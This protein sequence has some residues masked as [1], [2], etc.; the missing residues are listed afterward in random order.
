M[1]AL[2]PFLDNHGLGHSQELSAL[3]AANHDMGPALSALKAP[4]VL[5]VNAHA[6]QR[7][8]FARALAAAN[9]QSLEATDA[10]SMFAILRTEPTEAVLV[11]ADLPGAN[12]ETILSALRENPPCPNLQVLLTSSSG[13]AD[14][15]AKLLL[16][17]ADDYLRLP[18]TP[19]QLAARVKSALSHKDAQDR[20]DRLSRQL[21]DMNAELERSLGARTTDAVQARNAL[22]LALARLVEYRSL[23]AHS[24]LTRMQRHCTTLAQEAAGITA[25]ADQIDPDFLQNIECCAPLHDIGNVGL[26]DHILLKAGR[27]DDKEIRI[28]QTHTTVGADTLQHVAHRFGAKLGF[29][30]MAIDITRH[31]HENYDGSGYPDRLAGNN[32]PLAARIL[33]IADS[34]DSLRSRRAQ[35]PSL[36]HPSSLQIMF[37]NSPGKYDPLL[38]AALKRC[39]GQFERIFRDLPDTITID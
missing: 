2:L 25:F 35:R 23:E 37:D 11:A 19:V 21:L 24:H 17:G 12:G 4:R 5:I 29:L 34:Y 10:D 28:M 20:Q 27:L 3:P 36:S 31:H 15:M 16:A 6:D 8:Q 14:E 32:I 7:R 22:V 39:A 18:I 1:H 26:P 33:T 13:A 9:V 38:M 30:S